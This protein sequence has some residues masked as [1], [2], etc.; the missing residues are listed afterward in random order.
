MSRRVAYNANR[1][2]ISPG[3]CMARR[4]ESAATDFAGKFGFE[5]N[6]A[7]A[8]RVRR[9]PPQISER[10][11]AQRVCSCV[12]PLGR[13]L[14]LMRNPPPRKSAG[15]Y[16]GG[17]QLNLKWGNPMIAG[18]MSALGSAGNFRCVISEPGS[19]PVETGPVLE[20]RHL[21]ARQPFP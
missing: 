21:V 18:E 4:R 14:M 17:L 7:A 16:L 19:Q 13:G 5:K 3:P 12:A 9:R 8:G 20:R 11:F 6:P 1:V 2:Y 10:E 15:G